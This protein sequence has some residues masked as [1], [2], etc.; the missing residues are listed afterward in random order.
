MTGL[1]RKAT[2][3]TACGMLV[4]AA[5]MAGVPSPINSTK[6]SYIDVVGTNSGVPDPYG[7]FTI[8]VRDLGSNPIANSQVVLDFLAC[9]DMNLCGDAVAGQTLDCPTR[10]VRGFTDGTGSITFTV[11]G[12]AKNLGAAAG[13][14]AGCVN[15]LA[16][17]VSLIHATATEIDENGAIS[18]NGVEVTDLSAWLKDLGTGFYFGRSDFNHLGS[19]DIVDLSVW[20]GRLGTGQSASGCLSNIYCL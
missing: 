1:V 5:V 16:D 18:T 6:P 15:I 11:V 8:V 2:L 12:A 14:G 9:T 3:L 20:L 19:V 4:A 13:P 17:G 10:T 7:T